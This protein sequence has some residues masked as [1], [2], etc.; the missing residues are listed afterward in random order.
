MRSHRKRLPAQSRRVA[1]IAVTAAAMT[2][3]VI[4]SSA[5]AGPLGE[6]SGRAE[7]ARGSL[8][9]AEVT[10]WR[11]G[12]APGRARAVARGRT[13]AAGRFRLSLARV[14]AQDALY[15][16]TRGGRVG[17]SA[18]PGRF[19][20]ATALGY[21]RTGVLVLNER[22][23]V[24]TGFA[25]SQFLVR[26][27]AGGPAPGLPNA[28]A[29]VGNLVNP[30]TGGVSRLMSRP[31]N[32]TRTSA[33]ATMN[34]LAGILAR[35]AGD[36][37]VCAR[38][39]A[40]ASPPGGPPARGTLQAIAGIAARPAANA[41]AIFRLQKNSRA[42]LPRLRSAPGS[43]VIGIT[44][45]GNGR[46]FRGPGN[47]AFDA[48]GNVWTTNNYVPAGDPALV[49][50]GRALLKLNPYSPGA[51]VDMYRGGGINGAGFGIGIDPRGDI[52]VGNFGF[53]GT[54]CAEKEPPPSDSVSR[55]SPTGRPLSGPRGYRDGDFRFPQGTVSDRRGTIWIAA[56][57]SRSVVRYPGGDNTRAE[58]L[59]GAADQPMRDPFDVVIDRAGNGWVTSSGTDQVFAFAP[60]G[61]Q[62]PG[63][64]YSGGGLKKPLGIATD[65]RGNQWVANSG[66]IPIP[67]EDTAA[68]ATPLT[69]SRAQPAGTITRVTADGR[70]SG[71][72]GGGLTVPWGIATDG[73]GNVWVANFGGRRVSHFCGASPG[74]C[75]PGVRV[76]APLSPGAGY[77]FDGLQRNTGINIDASGN[78]W[79]ANNWK[80]V[81]VQSN[82]GG[83]GLVAFV[84]L[85][86]PVAM[87]L[88]GPPRAP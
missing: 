16:T 19:Q 32:G 53:T 29:M 65:A 45:A 46:Q 26:A 25:M 73:A 14:S 3:A 56:C 87:P 35:C 27:K 1:A 4:A 28:A 15:L 66:V 31:P 21:Q 50:P 83:N 76:G 11:A 54:K 17:I 82:P 24:A 33:L 57:G 60:D 81:P 80:E 40:L 52:W 62:L 84:G 41:S 38:L 22:T 12:T 69:G 8:A 48:A 85:A 6:V 67:C 44:F 58:V 61:S 2:A 30:R 49:C 13:D 37:A 20:L 47:I 5:A 86:P 9:L 79:V 77:G 78:V 68:A 23:T 70:V 88:I 7:T 71:L 10:L 36:A 59:T 63:S 39:D 18:V 72:S 34:T 55:F 75:P 43:W 64:P 42:Y 74:A 51:R